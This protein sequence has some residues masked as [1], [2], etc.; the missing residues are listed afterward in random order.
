MGAYQRCSEESFLRDLGQWADKHNGCHRW[1]EWSLRPGCD[2]I[3]ANNLGKEL[4]ATWWI[5]EASWAQEPRRREKLSGVPRS[6]CLKGVH[7][8]QNYFFKMRVVVKGGGRR[9]QRR[10]VLE[11]LATAKAGKEQHAPDERGH[12]A[13]WLGQTP[14]HKS[15][16][17]TQGVER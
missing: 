13:K 4:W 5:V 14:A 16:G 3:V 2:G 8:C 12:P 9:G 15:S 1:G 7:V 10:V 6:W 11:S 17:H